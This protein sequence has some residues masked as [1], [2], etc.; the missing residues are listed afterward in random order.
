M[1]RYLY[2]IILLLTIPLGESYRIWHTKEINLKR[3]FLLT[4]Q[5]QDLEWYIKDSSEGLIWIL[6][7]IVWLNREKNRSKVWY[8]L[9]GL[10]LCFRIV[11]LCAYWVNHRHAG[12]IYFFCYL[13]IIIYAGRYFVI[14]TIKRKRNEKGS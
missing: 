8:W 5:S 2:P 11:D 3:W 10:F 12:L 13:T 7:L 14:N 4:D 9:I 1:K 6:F